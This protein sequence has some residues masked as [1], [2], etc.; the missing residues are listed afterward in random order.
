MNTVFDR[1]HDGGPIA[2][3]F[4][5]R[6]F[7][8][9][10]LRF[11]RSLARVQADLGVIPHAAAGEIGRVAHIENIDL[12]L[13]KQKTCTV[14]LPIVGLVEQIVHLC[15][16]DLGQY[17]HYGA[18]TQDV[19][20]CALAL[21]MTDALAMVD[22]ALGDIAQSLDE[23]AQRHEKTMQAGRT[24]Q[25]HALPLT[26]GFKT[27][28]WASGIHRQRERLAPLMT[29]AC[30]GQLG[31]AVGTLASFGEHGHATRERLMQALGLR[32]PDIAWHSMR[33]VPAEVALFL[34]QTAATLAKIARDVLVLSSTEVAE[35]SF[36]ADRG[37]SST[38]PQKNNPVSASSVVALSRMLFHVAPM[39]LDAAVIENERSLDAWYIELH[40][41]PRCFALAGGVLLHT[42]AMLADMRVHETRMLQNT[43]ITKGAIVSETVQMAVAQ[44]VGLNRAHDLVSR[45]CRQSRADG[46]PL[47]ESLRMFAPEMAGT[48]LADA[49][50][51]VQQ[52]ALFSQRAIDE[53]R[54]RR[55]EVDVRAVPSSRSPKA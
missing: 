5:E 38:M 53:M 34:S 45:A 36:S 17:V 48:E 27:A 12:E 22:T 23:L 7:V 30:T 35:L 19:M 9:N 40:A 54:L 47:I 37:S 26:F 4:S 44:Q 25:Q 13:L 41:M 6:N 33:D 15:R 51:D 52:H 21:Q 1:L 24:N 10:C 49:L 8:A 50:F 31:G 43:A 2:A 42:Q 20:D 14:G 55:T 18:T 29:R 32:E 46:N 28:V 11:E 16:D 3:T 39:M